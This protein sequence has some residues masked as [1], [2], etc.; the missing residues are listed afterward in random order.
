VGN[1]L[2]CPTQ[3]FLTIFYPLKNKTVFMYGF[4]NGSGEFVSEFIGTDKSH[5]VDRVFSS[6]SDDNYAK[7]FLSTLG[8]MTAVGIAVI[9]RN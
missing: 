4:M 5:V 8:F 3:K 7:I 2:L 9:S 1:L 6:Q